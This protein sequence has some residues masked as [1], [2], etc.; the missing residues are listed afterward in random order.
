MA[1]ATRTAYDRRCNVSL[2]PPD[3]KP[4]VMLLPIAT[5]RWNIAPPA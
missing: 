3:W 1:P 4:A 5:Y 2:I